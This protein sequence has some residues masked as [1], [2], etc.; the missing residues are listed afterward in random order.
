MRSR[1]AL[2]AVAAACR[3]ATA[4]K[5]LQL[6]LGARRRS[7]NVVGEVAQLARRLL[8]LPAF[9]ADR[10]PKPRRRRPFELHALDVSVHSAHQGYEGIGLRSEGCGLGPHRLGVRAG[11]VGVRGYSTAG[12]AATPA[13]DRYRPFC[14]EK[15]LPTLSIRGTVADRARPGRAGRPCRGR[16]AERTH[17]RRRRRVPGSIPAPGA[18]ALGSAARALQ[19]ATA[20]VAAERPVAAQQRPS[21]GR[22]SRGRPET[23]RADGGEKARVRPRR[24]RGR[25]RGGS[26]RPAEGT[27]TV[28]RADTNDV[29]LDDAS[30]SAAHFTVRIEGASIYVTD[31]GAS[32]GLVIGEMR[33]VP[34][35]EHK[36]KLGEVLEAGRVR[37]AFEPRTGVRELAAE[38]GGWVRFNRP[39]RMTEPYE[40]PHVRIPAA[41]PD[42]RP[43]RIPVLA[44]LVPVLGAVGLWLLSENPA[45][46]LFAALAP[47]TAVFTAFVTRD[48]RSEASGKE[49]RRTERGSRRLGTRSTARGS[50]RRR[51]ERMRR[52]TRASCSVGPRRSRRASGSAAPRIA[53]SSSCASASR[54]SNRRSRSS[55][56]RGVTRRSRRKRASYSRRRE[57]SPTSR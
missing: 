5:V 21:P 35:S 42:P 6:L 34:G 56:S 44:A 15:V 51:T 23:G 3:L 32:N 31:S 27:S 37:M 7:E 46:L 12:G 16:R 36:A 19:R 38:E 29:R 8:D 33:L 2:R 52:P 30:V 18:R 55:S 45:T 50:A 25:A 1:E 57:L 49:P 40:P 14:S 48:V 17:A 28:G 41:P 54:R 9:A 53:T 10:F 26:R 20:D 13:T 39:P 4:P 43:A 22:P 11:H 24:A 47:L